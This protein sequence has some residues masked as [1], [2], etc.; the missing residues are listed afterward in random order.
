MGVVL[1]DDSGYQASGIAFEG[2]GDLLRQGTCGV[3]GKLR[4]GRG[5]GGGLL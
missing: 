1:L 2:A 5:A 3:A 4:G